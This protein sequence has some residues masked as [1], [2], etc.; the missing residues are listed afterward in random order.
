LTVGFDQRLGPRWR[1]AGD[2]TSTSLSSTLAAGGVASTPATGWEFFYLAQLIGVDLLTNGD[3]GRLRFR[4]FDGFGYVGYAL[5]ASGRF[6]LLQSFWITP[7]LDLDYRNHDEM[8]DRIA[9]QPGLRAEYRRGR[10]TLEADVRGEWLRSVGGGLAQPSRDAYG[11]LLDVT[12]RW[13][14]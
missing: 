1:L 14:F 2:V 12:V 6:P 13:L 10:L 7:R 11:Y 4:V 3:T 9:V 5:G 8:S